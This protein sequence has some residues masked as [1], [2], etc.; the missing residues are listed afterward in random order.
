M[1]EFERLIADLAGARAQVE[2]AQAKV[3]SIEGDLIEYMQQVRRKTLKTSQGGYLLQT[4]VST[5]TTTSVD[6]KGLR[7]RLGAK[8]FDRYTK[9]VL[10]KKLLEEALES[11][12]VDRVWVAPFV[13]VKTSDP[14]VV[15]T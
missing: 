9:R 14:F 5:R 11:G 8:S 4:T 1:Q 2:F 6:E 10:D 15:F 3:K 7:K 13:T 12:E